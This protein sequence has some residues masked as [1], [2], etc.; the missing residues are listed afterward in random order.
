MSLKLRCLALAFLSCLMSAPA[1]AQ[2]DST[3]RAVIVRAGP[4]N[5]FPQV[6]RLPNATNVFVHGCLVGR[7]WCDIQAGRTRGWVPLSEITRSARVRDA[8]TVT[9]SVADYWDAHYRTRAWYASRDR[10]LDWGTPGFAP[11]AAPRGS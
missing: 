9:F 10:W 6:A 7:T 8:A 1:S 2:L 11:P 4:D 5:A 3:R